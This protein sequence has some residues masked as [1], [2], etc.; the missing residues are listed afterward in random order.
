MR[1]LNFK[2]KKVLVRVDFNVP[3]GKN[4][5]VTDDTRIRGAL[6]T[7]NYVL[8][9]GGSLILMSHLSR[10]LKKLNE[11]GSINVQ[12]FTLRH[13]I[14]S[15]SALLG[16]QVDFAADCIGEEAVEKS[17]NLQPGQ[18]L[19]LENT[20]FYKE[21]ESG[22]ADFAKKLAS[23]A[24]MFVNDAFGTAHRAHA[25]T[26]IVAKYF[27]KDQKALGLLMGKEVMNAEKLMH[28]TPHPFTAI[29]GGAKVSDKIQLLDTLIQKADNILI[30]GGMAFT[31]IRA[32]G[33]KIGNSLLEADYLTLA[34]EL[35]EKAKARGVQIYLP[36]DSVISD[37]FSEDGEIKTVDSYQI[38]DEWLGLDIGNVAIDEY[39]EVIKQSKGILWNG[40]LGVFEM[41]KF[42]KGTFEIAAAIAEATQNGAFSLIGGGDSVSAINK[43]GLDDQVSY[44]S[45]GGGAMLEFFEGKVLPGIAAIE[46]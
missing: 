17:G 45:T 29:I 36:K 33:G 32:L 46:E 34:L 5:E 30:G 44:I 3:L 24:D 18:V 31:F 4:Y 42:A 20:R 37:K 39:R 35:L 14:P 41:E 28:D 8:D 9:Q 21:E 19:L 38:P 10:P 6:P 13:I 7:L 25:S 2:N 16:V 22:N 11:D 15:L 12:K 40:P 27:S 43:S 1:N 26:T 23:L